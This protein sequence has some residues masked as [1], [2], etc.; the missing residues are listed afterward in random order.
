MRQKLNFFEG[1]SP[2][3]SGIKLTPDFTQ[4]NIIPTFK[5]GGGSVM[6]WGCFAASGP[7]QKVWIAFVFFKK[8]VLGWP[9]SG[10]KS[11]PDMASMLKN[12]PMCLK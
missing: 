2:V 9:K 11:D 6:V 10:L 8:Q 4:K 1:F 7:G 12:P 5:L 3:T